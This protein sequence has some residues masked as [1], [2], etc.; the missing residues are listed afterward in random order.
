MALSVDF[1]V[2]SSWMPPV[3]EC[4]TSTHATWT[5]Q[6]LP[7]KQEATKSAPNET[8]STLGE[9]RTDASAEP[10]DTEIVHRSIS[11]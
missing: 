2:D 6:D 3:V 9:L 8:C 11:V 10:T 7:K 1:S 5:P 4:Y